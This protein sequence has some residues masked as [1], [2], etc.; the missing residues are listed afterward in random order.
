MRSMALLACLV[1]VPGFAQASPGR[2]NL[3]LSVILDPEIDPEEDREIEV[4]L[5]LANL[6]TESAYVAPVIGQMC[7]SLHI[8][9]HPLGRRGRSDILLYGRERLRPQFT[10]ESLFE[11]RAG[12]R[13]ELEKE[14]MYSD[15]LTAEGAYELWAE[16]DCTGM[17]GIVPQAFSGRLRSNRARFVLAGPRAGAPLRRP[18]ASPPPPH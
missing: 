2:S 18:A 17:D 15:V 5:A 3:V 10:R 6:G 12:R 7:R 11:L 1:L 14:L 9:A 13:L 4:V 8:W 16:L